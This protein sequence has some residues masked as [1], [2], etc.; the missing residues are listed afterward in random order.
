MRYCSKRGASL[1]RYFEVH[2]KSQ[3]DPNRR[4]QN[5]LLPDF[6][7]R[8][9][10]DRLIS[11]CVRGRRPCRRVCVPG[12]AKRNL[13]ANLLPLCTRV[14]TD[15][16]TDRQTDT[17]DEREVNTPRRLKDLFCCNGEKYISIRAYATCCCRQCL[18]CVQTPMKSNDR[19]TTQYCAHTHTHT[20]THTLY[21]SVS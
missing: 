8:L 12:N 15:R 5:S 9:L 6:F 14:R 3:M 17:F 13:C 2:H 11:C 16:Q 19:H 1:G 21:A 7:L 20:H 10:F 4:T 18:S